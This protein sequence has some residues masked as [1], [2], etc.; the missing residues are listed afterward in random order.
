[1]LPDLLK[2]KFFKNLSHFCP[3]NRCLNKGPF[4]GQ[5]DG[6]CKMRQR[7]VISTV[8]AA[9]AIPCLG[10][11]FPR[12]AGELLPQ[13]AEKAA[14]VSVTVSGPASVVGRYTENIVEIHCFLSELTR[15]LLVP[16]PFETNPPS[17]ERSY[18]FT[19]YYKADMAFFELTSGGG[20]CWNGKNYCLFGSPAALNTLFQMTER[21]TQV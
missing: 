16:S 11:F 8:A 6:V 20:I 14:M 5:R 9:A 10:I 4:I 1:M 12:Q 21:W 17:S 19:V 13:P 2:I 15:L 18:C 7:S 3:L